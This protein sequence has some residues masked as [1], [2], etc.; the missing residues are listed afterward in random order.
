MF[1]AWYRVNV[2]KRYIG[3]SAGISLELRHQRQI[4]EDT[5]SACLSIVALQLRAMPIDAHHCIPAPTFA[6]N[7]SP[8]FFSNFPA[9]PALPTSPALTSLTPT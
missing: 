8:L 4:G 1:Y 2:T 3:G 6:A 7:V 9:H 5:D